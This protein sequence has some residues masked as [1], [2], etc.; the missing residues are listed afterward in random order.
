[1]PPGFPPSAHTGARGAKLR[2]QR[3]VGATSVFWL[4]KNRMNLCAPMFPSE[5]DSF[6]GQWPVSEQP[7][8]FKFLAKCSQIELWAADYEPT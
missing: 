1:M 6:Q 7:N 5:I 4:A 2:D 3:G 8:R